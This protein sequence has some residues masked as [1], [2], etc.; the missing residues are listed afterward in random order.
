MAY[1]VFNMNMIRA[2]NK[3]QPSAIHGVS[4]ERETLYALEKE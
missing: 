1:D 3:Y 2:S 4:L